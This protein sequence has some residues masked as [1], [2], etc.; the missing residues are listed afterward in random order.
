MTEVLDRSKIYID[1]AWVDSQG[2][3]RIDVVNPA[4]EEVIA[5]VAD[6]TAEDV[7]R[8]AE[9]ARAAF[10]AW[11]ALSGEE[12]GQYLRKA[13]G[14]VKERVDELAALVSSDMGMPVRLAKPV[15]IGMPL[16]NL[17]AF[18]ELA[19]N[20]NFDA[21]EVG[22]SL[23]VREPIGVVGAITPW[24]FPLHQVVLKVGGALA[25]G[26]TVVLKPTEVAPL[27]TYA[28][29]DIFHEVG[30]PAGVFNL[31]SGYGPVVG[32]AIAGHP[33][34]D[35]VSF[36]GSTRAGKRVAVVAAETVKKVALELGGK[37][38]N[39]ILDDAD[40]TKAVTDG[41]GKC[42]L[43]SGQ[44]CSALTRMLVPADKVDEAAAIAAQVAQNYAVGDPTAA[45]S[46]L[47]PLVNSNQLKRVRS[48][49]E[50]GI[51]EG[52]EPVLDGRETGQEKGY[53]VGPTIFSG[54]TEDM[55]IAREEIFG[56]VLSIIGYQDEEDAVRI[57]NATEYGLAGG[58]WSGDKDRADRVARRLRAG[59]V[60]VNGGAF[61][62]NAPFGGYKQSG[63]GREAGV[64]GFE[65][66]LEVKSI[67]R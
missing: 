30:L 27:T 14:L 32:E 12:R 38:A 8:A 47:G 28:L 13:A 57:A 16:A 22:N 7:D 1:G 44:T 19:A 25:A 18:A 29:T 26:C 6:G 23:I 10:P 5:V 43:N 53:F 65:E 61:N 54:V 36:T 58:V 17:S 20:Y 4:T 31:V 64:L 51:A 45:T 40:L 63:I 46:V 62:T 9:A 35:M 48:Y 11:S 34:V 33:E 59:Q 67:Q 60:E 24:N 66:F 52:A 37:S 55:T 3:G 2:T 50:Q 39:V 56:P 42:Y 49:I 41:V 15:Q 21:Q